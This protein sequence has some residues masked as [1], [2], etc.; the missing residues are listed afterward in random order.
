VRGRA[1]I[2]AL[3]LMESKNDQFEKTKDQL[4]FV[5]PSEQCPPY[6]TWK[7]FVLVF[8]HCLWQAAYHGLIASIESN[9][10]RYLW[11]NW[12]ATRCIIY[13]REHSSI[14]NSPQRKQLDV[15]RLEDRIFYNQL[16]ERLKGEISIGG[17]REVE[18]QPGVWETNI[19]LGG[20]GDDRS[21]TS[22]AKSR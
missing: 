14:R 11:I 13:N 16:E 8:H 15:T 21:R 7:G 12:N 20:S 17:P 18:D 19:A 2:L 5:L 10:D 6:L 1:H 4:R 22:P 3:S 9:Q